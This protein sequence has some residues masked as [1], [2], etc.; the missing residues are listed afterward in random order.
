[1]ASP[2]KKLEKSLEFLRALQEQGVV[3]VRSGDLTRTH[4]ERLVKNGFLQVVMKGWYIPV[5]PDE[6]TGESTA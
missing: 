3:V 6:V 2:H 1:M 4:R 5:H